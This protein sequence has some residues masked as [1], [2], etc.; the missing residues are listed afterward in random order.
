MTLQESHWDSTHTIPDYTKNKEK[1]VVWF[2]DTVGFHFTEKSFPSFHS[3]PQLLQKV[4]NIF[5]YFYF[6][7]F[8]DFQFLSDDIYLGHAMP[9]GVSWNRAMW[10]SIVRYLQE[11]LQTNLWGPHTDELYYN[12]FLYELFVFV[13]GQCCQLIT[14]WLKKIPTLVFLCGRRW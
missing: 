5:L 12:K 6:A 2:Q 14:L 1:E 13:G 4:K 8:Q 11:L 7:I 9:F 3:H 10:W